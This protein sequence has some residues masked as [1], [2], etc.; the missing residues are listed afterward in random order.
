MGAEQKG[1][2]WPLADHPLASAYHPLE[3]SE[4]DAQTA[5]AKR[6]SSMAL[7]L[8]IRLTIS[9][10]GNVS[11]IPN[12]RPVMLGVQSIDMTALQTNTVGLAKLAKMFALPVVLTTTG[13]GGDGP[14]DSH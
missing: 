12:D 1:R 2:V 7:R 13:G 5:S 9:T 14:S 3:T 6:G 8:P 11:G 4:L 10:S